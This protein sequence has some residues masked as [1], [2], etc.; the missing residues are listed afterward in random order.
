M[1]QQMA[2]I[3]ANLERVLVWPQL[4]ISSRA[5][6]CV[7]VR[8]MNQLNLFVAAFYS[9]WLIPCFSQSQSATPGQPG[10]LSIDQAV[11]EALERNIGLLAER[12]NVSVAEARMVTARLRPNPVV[13]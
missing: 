6:L 13:S 11:A 9:L 7:T 5:Y 12:Y 1:L 8:P 2:G 3:Q 10:P 4:C